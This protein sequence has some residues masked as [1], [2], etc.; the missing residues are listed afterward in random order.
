MC[1]NSKDLPS[2][3]LFTL[4]AQPCLSRDRV[5]SPRTDESRHAS[6]LLLLLL[7]LRLSLD[8]LRREEFDLLH[9]HLLRSLGRLAG[10][11]RVSVRQQ[12][13]QEPVSFQQLYN[14]KIDANVNSQLFEESEAKALGSH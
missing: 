9:E 10:G 2:H 5:H 4:H 13:R 6:L 8:H 3:A 12:E 11:L 14:P 7:L 1:G